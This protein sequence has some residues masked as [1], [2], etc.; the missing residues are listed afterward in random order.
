MKRKFLKYCY[1]IGRIISKLSQ[2]ILIIDNHHLSNE[3][4]KNLDKFKVNPIETSERIS[5]SLFFKKNLKH[6]KFLNNDSFLDIGCGNGNNLRYVKKK[7]KRSRV[8]GCDINDRYKNIDE[9]I[10]FKLIDLKKMNSLKIY[11]SKSIDHVYMIHTLNHIFLNNT[12]NTINLR[13]NII[14]NMIRVAK[15]NVFIIENKSFV[16]DQDLNTEIFFQNK[17]LNK[18]ELNYNL[19]TI[20]QKKVSSI[21]VYFTGTKTLV[22]Q[23]KIN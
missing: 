3:F 9:K 17:S 14:T 16:G 5:R 22:Y 15:K 6:F 23:L 21:T 18:I 12:K 11:K 10:N 1:L 7:F 13:K 20:L 8:Y 19:N 4:Y 2:N